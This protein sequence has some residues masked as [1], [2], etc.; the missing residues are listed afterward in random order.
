MVWV[1][2]TTPIFVGRRRGGLGG[3]SSLAAACYVDEYG[4]QLETVMLV[5]EAR[6]GGK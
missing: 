6:V 2:A 5:Y 1:A 3:V 4:A